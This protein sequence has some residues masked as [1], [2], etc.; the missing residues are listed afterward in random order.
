MAEIGDVTRFTHRGA[1]T[2]F[3]GVDP[4]KNDSKITNF[5]L[6]FY[7]QTEHENLERNEVNEYFYILYCLYTSLQPFRKI[8]TQTHVLAV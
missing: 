2:V 6:T 5:C 3:A 7:L 8:K 4:G 1:L